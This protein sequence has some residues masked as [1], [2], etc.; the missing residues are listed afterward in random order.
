MAHQY[1]A[2]VMGATEVYQKFVAP[3]TR[4][5]SPV[6]IA[7]LAFVMAP[8]I[9]GW[10]AQQDDLDARLEHGERVTSWKLKKPNIVFIVAILGGIGALQSDAVADRRRKLMPPEQ[11]AAQLETETAYIKRQ[12]AQG[13]QQPL[14]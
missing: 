8:A 11:Q 10:I 5:I 1:I 3:K 4:H 9:T 6:M 2:K 12:I 14:G 7:F 13:K